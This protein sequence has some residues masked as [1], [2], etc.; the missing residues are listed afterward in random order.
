L[1][2]DGELFIFEEIG[3]L[4]KDMGSGKA[5]EGSRCCDVQQAFLWAGVALSYILADSECIN[6]ELPCMVDENINLRGRRPV[7]SS[8]KVISAV[9][10]YCG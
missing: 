3:K 7:I 4:S 9:P 6:E 8:I 5:G 2:R 1:P 10:K